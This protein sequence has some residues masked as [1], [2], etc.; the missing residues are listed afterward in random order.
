MP[1]AIDTRQVK[2]AICQHCGGWVMA[3]CFP[4]SEKRAD[5]RRA[6]TKCVNAGHEIKVV[7]LTEW[8]TGPEREKMCMGHKKTKA[9]AADLFAPS[10]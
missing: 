9:K 4:E 7:L 8:N 2:V 5:S 6:W 1:E 3:G 10:H